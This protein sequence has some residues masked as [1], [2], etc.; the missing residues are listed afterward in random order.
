MG[1]NNGS[2]SGGQLICGQISI[3]NDQWFGF[4]AGSTTIDINI[5]TSNCVT[6]DGLQAAFFDACAVD[7]LE[8]NPGS[9]GG[10]GGPLPL[11]YSNFVPG[12]TYFLM[13]DGY[14]GDV[15]DFEIEVLGGS[16][17][18]PPPAAPTQP[19]GPT[20]VCPGASVVYT[21]PDVE[22]AGY[23]NWIGPAGSSIN[24]GSN[25][26]NIP[27]PEG[28]TVTVTFGNAGGQLCVRVGNACFPAQ[29]SCITIVNQPIP[30][31]QLPPITVCYED[32]PFIWEEAPYTA[33]GIPGTFTLTSLPYDSYLGCDSTVKQLIKVKNQIKTNLNTIYTCEGSCYQINGNSYCQSGGP[34]ME[35]FES[36]QGCDSVV[37]FSVVVVPAVATIAPALTLDC[38]SPTLTLNSNGSTTGPNVIYKWTNAAWSTLGMGSTQNVSNGGVYN[39]VVTNTLGN[40]TCKDTTSITVNSNIVPPGA[41]AVGGDFNCLSNSVTLQGSSPTNGVNYQWSGPGITPA[42]TNLQ[43][44]NINVQGAYTLVVTNP[45]N[46]CTST[47]V[48]IVNSDVVVPSA[49]A[50]GGTLSCGQTSVVI[51]GMTNAP[52][53]GFN[54]SGPGINPGN[55]TVENPPVTLSGTYSVTIT[56][57]TNGCSNTAST[58]VDQNTAIPSANAGADQTINCL[59]SS[60]TLNGSGNTGAGPTQFLWTGPGIT[61]ANESLATPSVNVPGQYI[62][63]VTNGA[64]ACFNKDTVLVDAQ[65]TPPTVDAGADAIINCTTP[66]VT[67]NGSGSSTGPNF[68]PLWS[69]PGITGANANL[70]SPSVTVSGAYT[71]LISNSGN[72]CTA[73]DNVQVD[74]NTTAPT[75]DAGADQILTCTSTN[76]ITLNG[77]GS[78][79]NVT[80]LW[81]GLGIGANNET[82]QNPVVTQPDTYTL[83]TTDPLNGCTATDQVVVLQD[84]NV[85]T[86]SAGPDLLLNCSVATVDINASGTS[87]GAGISYMWS[88]PG[89]TGANATQLSPLNITLPGAYQLTV[90]NSNNNCIN[91]DIVVVEID[92]ITPNITAGPDMILNCYNGASDTLDASASSSGPEFVY[93]WAGPGIS[94][95]NENDIQPIV[96]ING[97]YSLTIT[98]T[99]NTCT[100]TASAIVSNDLTPPVADAGT[101]KTID[102]VITSAS[103]GGNSSSGFG[104]NYQ[105]TGP[106]IIPANQ[107]VAQPVVNL[108]G[109]YDLVVTD[110]NNGCTSA[111]TVLVNT[112]A[113]FP[114]ANAGIDD[115][116]TCAQTTVTL[117]G[118]G[119]SSGAGMQVL[120]AGPDITPVNQNQISPNIGLP[121]TYILSVTNTTN[122]CI[123]KDS[124]V[125]DLNQTAPVADITAGSNLDCQISSVV[126]DGSMS[127]SGPNFTYLWSGPGI[128]AANADV[129]DPS[130]GQP[131][132]YVLLVTDND[133]GCTTT[134]QTTVTQDIAIPT[135]SAGNDLTL[136]CA[137]ATQAIDGAASSNGPLFSYV[138][139]G[140]GINTNNFSLQS[141]GV[142]EPGTYTVTV[143]NTQN[144]CTAMD[145]VFVG[146]DITPPLTAAGP[147]NTLTCALDTLQLDGALSQSGANILYAWTGPG[148]VAG[149]SML[150]SPNVFLP[151]TY[152]ITVTN[153]SNGCTNSDAV[154]VN[155]DVILPNADA[156]SDQTLTC[157]N[158]T[159][160]V[161]LNASAS[162]TGPGFSLVWSG[163]GISA[164]NQNAV[165]PI[166]LATGTY[167]VLITN[168]NTGCTATDAVNVL[169]DQNLPTAS[170]GPDQTITCSQPQAVLDGSGSVSP[171]GTLLYTWT[172]PG[173]T[174]GAQND[175]ITSVSAA[176]A[177]TLTVENPIT[178]CIASDIVTVLLD[179]QAPQVTVTSDIITCAEPLGDLSVSSSLPGSQFLW[180]GPALP[181]SMS[182]LAAF[183]VAT[184]GLYSVTVTAPNG[185]TTVQTAIMDV[186]NDFPDGSAEGALLDC[187]NNG[188]SSISGLVNTPGATFVWNGPNG[189]FFSN[190]LIPTVTQVGTYTL[191][192]TSSVGCDREIMVDVLSD[193]IPPQANALVTNQLDCNTTSLGI[194][195]NGTSTGSIYTYLWTTADGNIV[196]GF[197]SL[198]PVVDA[199]G[200][201]QLLVTNNINGCQDSVTVKVEID[202]AVPTGFD[203]VVKEIRCFG[204]ANG[205][206]S[207]ASVQGGTAPFFYSINGGPLT[208][209]SEFVGLTAGTYTIAM[210]DA[211]GCKLDSSVVVTEP[212]KLQLELGADIEVQLG[213][214]AT[215][216]AQVTN[217]TPLASAIWNYAPGCDTSA[218]AGDCFEF[219]YIP[220]QSYRH[221]LSLLDSNGC[222]A[223]DWV[224]VVVKK[225][226]LV[227]VPNIFNPD[228]DDP[229]NSFLMIQG[230]LGVAKVRSWLIFDR[231]GDAVF[232]VREFQP[233]DISYAWDGN[234]RGDKGLPAVYV[235][236]AEIEFI[237]GVVEIFK[238]DVTL[239]R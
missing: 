172:G 10:G 150:I 100:A 102:C 180:E 99:V 42:N 236:Y 193:F 66:A 17:T 145:M 115:I 162:N 114:I 158:S 141:P 175:V 50:V 144:H 171:G 13:V 85:P 113:V 198:A 211:N 7:A 235:W 209:V 82:Q 98:N 203:P 147:D 53:A 156:G 192:I 15:C 64:N 152:Q 103:I 139:T 105:W 143:T 45:V 225:K 12:Q 62:L 77:G 56:N 237:D 84:A 133:N 93:L 160:G 138:W 178:G 27:A 183:Q 157:V 200:F 129:V 164:A 51:D 190:S 159:T 218:T 11:S 208:T 76:G 127:S 101:D 6:G 48:A 170:A 111:S 83:Q 69:G 4:V 168:N 205:T 41:A 47:A 22:N 135:A 182:T 30:A 181:G 75:V 214:E 194:T 231:W 230:G 8:C 163:P 2:P 31:T 73:T 167:N 146:E 148:I 219:T 142:S 166:V 195:T 37:Q 176:G 213:E 32:L 87:S 58:L 130:I 28:T 34:Y 91:T 207:I 20:L 74:L 238:G 197:S 204:Q 227:Y 174:A 154:T 81:S 123:T 233:N 78:P 96:N 188:I 107:T 92:T 122:S 120:W 43:N 177:Y 228:S 185:C 118:S 121:G 71:L 216:T 39:L 202:P 97:T 61:V 220:Y 57:N 9:N 179:N 131:G 215:I 112:N 187:T 199:P 86:A 68:T 108:A 128:T 137:L 201:Y 90:T 232:Q 109:T 88:G 33:I 104:F 79:A 126:L 65:I 125:V 151:G 35:L 55:Q 206:I 173:V 169:Q 124:V 94:A 25:N 140:P 36:F 222:A 23:Y 239:K 161:A 212:G 16:V 119:S 63:T 89:I 95:I 19:Q 184:P 116:I 226:R 80:F 221:Q 24:G 49:S 70:V 189:N 18:P 165:S 21:L 38:T 224:N 59:Q 106:G 196:S 14:T 40:A 26:V 217:T 52:N 3:H 72:G 54:W 155:Q 29:Q 110:T 1:I 67:L 153:T 44:P 191:V 149:E 186:S 229:L 117:N 136:T 132:S 223:V 134:A 5:A 60:V 46:H 210:E 234:V